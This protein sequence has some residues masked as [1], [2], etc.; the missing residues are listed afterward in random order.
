MVTAVRAHIIDPEAFPVTDT[1]PTHA[2]TVT[3]AVEELLKT[4]QYVCKHFLVMS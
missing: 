1:L 3:D 4:L 2:K